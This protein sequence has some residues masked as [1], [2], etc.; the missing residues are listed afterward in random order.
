MDALSDVL[1]AVR[2]NGAIF[3]DIHAAEPWVAE[4]PAGK[5]VV[6]AMFPNSEHLMCYHVITQGDCWATL[7]GREPIPLTAG[8]IIVFPHGDP[9]VLS[10]AQGL[11]KSPDLSL[12][13]RPKDGQLPSTIMIGEKNDSEEKAARFVCGFLG[14]DARPFNPLLAALPRVFKVSDGS[15]GALG[16]YVRHA[17]A[18]SQTPRIGGQG[19]LGHLSEL[20]FVDAVR[21]Y[22]EGLP[23]A[24]ASWL[25]ALRD[26]Q[27][28]RAIAALHQAPQRDWTL[29][30]LAR[31]VGLSRTALAEKFAAYVGRPPIQYLTQWRMQLA[32]NRL[33][34]TT[35]SIATVAAG[36]GYESE[37]AFSRVFKKVVGLPPSQWRSRKQG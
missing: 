18:E 15:G 7:D 14:C 34:N 2:L 27:V 25:T 31:N 20:M 9:H 36:V 11:R 21:R 33:A 35:D 26:P 30:S 1:Q 8:D 28:S 5:K 29:D 37:A 32:S 10:S 19:V 24:E 22:L 17:V 23:T 4:T 12:Y 16:A 13:R 6:Q 3:F